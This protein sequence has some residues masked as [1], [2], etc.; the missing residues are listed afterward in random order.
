MDLKA[1]KPKLVGSDNERAVSPVIGVILMVAITVILAAVIAA[2]VLD[3]GGSVGQEAQA[4][5]TIEV[6]ESSQE[7]QVEVT[8]MGNS[9]LVKLG[10][11][12][13]GIASNAGSTISGDHTDMQTGDVVTMDGSSWSSTSGASASGTITAI[14]VIEEDETET[15]VASEEYDF[16]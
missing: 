12:T 5:V 9:D 7:I 16:S 10:G 11:A 6:D 15:Q 14:A 3:L 13:D 1:L 4:G 2:F 8:S